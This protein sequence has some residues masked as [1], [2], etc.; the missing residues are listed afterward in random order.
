MSRSD[1]FGGPGLPG[2]VVHE[3][4]AS[5]AEQKEEQK[6]THRFA[7]KFFARTFFRAMSS[8]T[9]S[10]AYLAMRCVHGSVHATR[11]GV[12]ANLGRRPQ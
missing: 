4:N 6:F 3:R 12:A 11:S 9:R 7:P 5:R 2:S 8:A 1:R 10:L